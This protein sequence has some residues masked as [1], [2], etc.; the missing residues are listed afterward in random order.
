MNSVT[1]VGGSAGGASV[2]YLMA[3]PLAKGKNHFHSQYF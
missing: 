1:I 2:C 3:S